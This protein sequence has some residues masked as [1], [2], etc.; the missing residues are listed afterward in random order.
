[1]PL[2]LFRLTSEIAACLATPIPRSPMQLD[3]LAKSFPI[4]KA[5]GRYGYTLRGIYVPRNGWKTVKKY[6]AVLGEALKEYRLE[7]RYKQH[8][9]YLKWWIDNADKLAK[10][11]SMTVAEAQL[12]LNDTHLLRESSETCKFSKIA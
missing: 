2:Y 9:D 6:G 1:M 7:E 5:A 11:P 3:F 10:M 12:L 4:R 8:G